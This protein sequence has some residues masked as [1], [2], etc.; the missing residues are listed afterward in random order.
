LGAH[1]K[2]AAKL[3]TQAEVLENGS[4]YYI[5]NPYWVSIFVNLIRQMHGLKDLPQFMA[6]IVTG[7]IITTQQAAMNIFTSSL[8]F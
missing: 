6:E 7:L 4:S 5:Y 1:L 2:K 8:I 3:I